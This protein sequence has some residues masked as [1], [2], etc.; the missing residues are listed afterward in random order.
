LTGPKTEESARSDLQRI[1]R[2]RKDGEKHTET[3][4]KPEFDSKQ[5]S[6]NENIMVIG[7]TK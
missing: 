4:S 6:N 5:F 1:K 7:L 2:E 3:F